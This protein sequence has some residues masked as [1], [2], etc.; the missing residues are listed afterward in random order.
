MTTPS[1]AFFAAHRDA[2]KIRY[3]MSHEGEAWQ[4]VQNQEIAEEKERKK[5]MQRKRRREKTLQNEFQKREEAIERALRATDEEEKE[6][7]F[8]DAQ[9]AEKK[10]KATSQLLQGGTPSKDI[11]EVTPHAPNLEGGT[12]SSF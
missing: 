1:S 7:H 12:M 4:E 11:R 5:D 2:A 9:K 3:N 6:R 10:A 8:R